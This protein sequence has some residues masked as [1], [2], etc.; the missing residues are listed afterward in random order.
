MELQSNLFLIKANNM[1]LQELSGPEVVIIDDT[2]REIE[3]LRQTLIEKGI[4]TEFIKVDLEGNMPERGI[5]N[6]IK[7]VFLDLNYNINYG[8]TFDP[9]FCVELVSR[10]IPKDRQYYLVAWTK[11][12]DK[13][14]AVI[15]VLRENNL[16]PISYASKRKES[17]R[18]GATTY[19]I[20]KLLE[21][22]NSEFDKVIAVDNFVGEIV[23]ID[24]NCVLINCLIDPERGVYQIRRFDNTPF[25]NYIDLKVGNFISIRSTTK[26]G[27][28]SF[29]F[30]NESEDRAQLFKKPNYFDGLE[31][32]KFFTEK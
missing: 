8:S 15:E 19:N 27:S 17:F 7:L 9:H 20:D 29:E 32:S 24:G 4:N 3:S 22:L 5:I 23:E 25:I 1:F 11:D 31:N 26:P 2:E 28:R 18:T 16:M 30:F 13:T 10:V 14:E 21:E 6:T 12:P